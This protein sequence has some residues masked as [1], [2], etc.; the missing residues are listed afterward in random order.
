L[1]SSIYWFK[2]YRVWCR[3]CIEQNRL[4]LAEDFSHC[5]RRSRS[6]QAKRAEMAASEKKS[7]APVRKGGVDYSKWDAI[8][9]DDDEEDAK[10]RTSIPGVELPK[11]KKNDPRFARSLP[12]P[13]TLDPKPMVKKTDPRFSISAY[14]CCLNRLH[15]HRIGLPMVSM[16]GL[17]LFYVLSLP[18][19]RDVA[20]SNLPWRTQR[21]NVC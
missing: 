3:P 1:G 5:S 12:E 6:P 11:V 4:D 9:S 17:L 13:S 10:P 16:N 8:D 2:T 14:I 21:C 15:L 7:A 18:I 20:G 19:F